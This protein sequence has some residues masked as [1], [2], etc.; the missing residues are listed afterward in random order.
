MRAILETA[1]ERIELSCGHRSRSAVLEEG[2]AG[3]LTAAGSG[4]VDIRVTVEDCSRAFDTSGWE[5]FTRGAWRSSGRVGRVIVQDACS[6]GLDVLVTIDGD[7]LDMRARWRPSAAVRS[8][9]VVLR[10][11][12]RLLQRQVLLQYPAL[13]WAGQRRRAPLH[14]SVCTVGRDDGARTVMIAGPGGVGK[15]TLIQA[16]LCAG[17]HCTCDNLCTSDG[18][19]AWGVVEPMRVQV[20]SLLAVASLGRRMPHGRRE[21]RWPARITSLIPDM[22]VV[23][24]RGTTDTPVVRPLDP[25]QAARVLV[26]GTYMAGELRRYWQFAS[27]LALGTGVGTALAAVEAVAG[28]LAARL[29]CWEVVLARTPGARLAALLDAAE[30]VV[31]PMAVTR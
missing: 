2:A 23:L 21:T 14:A 28:D 11:R 27:T 19:T 29:P 24:R 4:P 31:E 8:A 12:S 7:V 3:E 9:D 5:P 20:D 30:P 15:S 16:E 17:A 22:L 6:S 1:G 13:W 18:R 26:A 25:E 10:S